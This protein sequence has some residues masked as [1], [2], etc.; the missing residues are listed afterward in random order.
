MTGWVEFLAVLAERFVRTS[1]RD[2]FHDGFRALAV[3]VALFGAP[4]TD[5]GL[6][7]LVSLVVGDLLAVVA[8]LRAFPAL[9]DLGVSRLSSCGE[10]SILKEP[11]C[12]RPFA[13]VHYHRSVGL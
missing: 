7:A 5:P 13:E 11:L 1:A 8:L 10:K 12:V 6:G 2:A 4:S 9:E 3:A